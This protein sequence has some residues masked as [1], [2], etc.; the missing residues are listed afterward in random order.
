ME[1]THIVD[2][3]VAE[4]RAPL[5]AAFDNVQ[6]PVVSMVQQRVIE[7]PAFGLFLLHNA[8]TAGAGG[9]PDGIREVEPPQLHAQGRIVERC[10]RGHEAAGK[11][12]ASA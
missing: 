9:E 3:T 8:S 5:L 6:V 12:A 4:H 10:G 7:Q 2:L 11:G 1:T